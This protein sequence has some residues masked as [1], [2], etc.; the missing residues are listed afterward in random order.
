VRSVG[1]TAGASA[2]EDLVSDV[3]RRLANLRPVQISTLNG[4]EEMVEFKLP[5]ELAEPTRAA[6]ADAGASS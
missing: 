3:V 5:P 6:I 2:P 4:P 1:L